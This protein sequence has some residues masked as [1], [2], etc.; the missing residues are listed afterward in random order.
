M[1]S[2]DTLQQCG[3]AILFKRYLNVDVIDSDED[4]EGPILRITVEIDGL[5]FQIL[6]IY[7]PNPD[8]SQKVRNFFEYIDQ[9]PLS[10]QPCILLGDLN[11]VF[12]LDRERAGANPRPLHTY[13]KNS[14][15]DVLHQHKVRDVWRERRPDKLKFTW[16]GRQVTEHGG[17]TWC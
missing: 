7:G 15:Q 1:V 13:G 9:F 17:T 16:G 5:K 14:L 11:M 12:D 6:T 8:L 3:V 4:F 2:L 10:N